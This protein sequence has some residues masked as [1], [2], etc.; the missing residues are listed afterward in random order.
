MTGSASRAAAGCALPQGRERHPG[1]VLR[2]EG[3]CGSH[4]PPL[5]FRRAMPLHRRCTGTAQCTAVQH[6]QAHPET[7]KISVQRTRQQSECD[8]LSTRWPVA[9]SF[10]RLVLKTLLRAHPAAWPNLVD[11]RLSRDQEG[12]SKGFAFLVRSCLS[13]LPCLPRNSAGVFLCPQ[14]D[15]CALRCLLNSR[16]C[17][18]GVNTQRMLQLAVQVCSILQ[19]L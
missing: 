8:P 1:A 10:S 18:P 2:W 4:T 9:R 7:R 19:V 12:Q 13:P 16:G 6:P 17:A 5:Y 11:V 3:P 14:R 15:A